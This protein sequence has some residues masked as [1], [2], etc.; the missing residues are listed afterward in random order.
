MDEVY[1]TLEQSIEKND[2]NHES[3]TRRSLAEIAAER[4]KPSTYTLISSSKSQEP[5]A[6]LRF[7]AV[8]CLGHTKSSQAKVAALMNSL[9]KNKKPDFILILGDNFNAWGMKTPHDFIFTSHFYNVY[10]NEAKVPYIA[11]TPCFVIKGPTQSA[12]GC[13]LNQIA[14]SYL[15][16]ADSLYPTIDSKINL[17]AKEFL[18]LDQ[19]PSWNMP[20]RF[21]SLKTKDTQL[22]CIDS[23]T[24]ISDFIHANKKPGLN[25]T[26]WLKEEVENAYR[27][28]KKTIL[29]LY[30]PAII[31]TKLTKHAYQSALQF[32]LTDDEI[33]ETQKLLQ[34]S[35]RTISHLTYNELIKKIFTAQKLTFNLTLSAHDHALY[36]FN[37]M[38]AKDT[39]PLCQLTSGGGGGDHKLIQLTE[40]AKGQ[41]YEQLGFFLEQHGF[42]EIISPD[43]N[44][45]I[46]FNIYTPNASLKFDNQSC[47]PL[48]TFPEE[49]KASEREAIQI[50]CAAVDAALN[51]YFQLLN[52][53]ESAANNSETFLGKQYFNQKKIKKTYHRRPVDV[54]RAYKVWTYLCQ[55]KVDDLQTTVHTID[56]IVKGR[57]V[58]S[59]SGSSI[60][61][62]SFVQVLNRKLAE[63]YDDA[64]I[65]I[66]NVYQ[67]IK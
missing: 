29:A 8:A 22:F 65:T 56:R 6:G 2:S 28:H 47:V 24:Y 42:T 5:I 41:V 4:A 12:S 55:A 33:R 20:S 35:D 19:L 18:D 14:H 30:H 43:Q 64:T 38:N 25:Q 48:R 21:Y 15:G 61:S 1:T 46:L 31:L 52:V 39:H 3:R 62:D 60:S 51:E 7:F 27:E 9:A 13:E 44:N 67:R 45:K 34:L 32:Y 10:T 17:Y 26:V 53:N 37:N 36:Y 63:F 54:R 49:M 58:I 40:K 11:N 23:T 16:R 57:G 59:C 66:E 50:F